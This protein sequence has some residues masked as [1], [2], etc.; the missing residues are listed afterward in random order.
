MLKGL[1]LFFSKLYYG[2][3]KLIPEEQRKNFYEEITNINH[4]RIKPL[5]LALFFVDLILVFLDLTF[6]TNIPRD[7]SAAQG[8]LTLHLLGLFVFLL[9]A[10]FFFF[11]YF[12]LRFWAKRFSLVLF[13][14]LCL[15]WCSLVSL[16]TYKLYGQILAIV[17]GMLSAACFFMLNRFSRGLFFSLTYLLFN[18]MLR[19]VEQNPGYIAGFWIDTTIVLVLCFFISNFCFNTFVDQYI[20]RKIIINNIKEIGR[21]NA[22]LEQK[23][24]ERTEALTQAYAQIEL[25]KLRVSFFTNL[26]H[27]F[28]TPINVILSAQQLLMLKLKMIVSEED[29]KSLKNNI[30]SIEKYSYRL[31]R[32]VSNTIDITRIDT[33][34]YDLCLKNVNIVHIVEEIV[35]S[36]SSFIEA[37]MLSIVF[38][39][40]TEERIMAVDVDKIERAILN[41]LSNAIK[42]TPKNGHIW[43]NLYEEST[44]FY[45]SVRDSGIGIPAHMKD[46]IFN[47]FVQVDKTLTRE[48]EGSG[49]GLSIV[50]SII[51]L[52]QG[53]ITVNSDLYSGSEFIICLPIHMLNDMGQY[54][55][56][57]QDSLDLL[58]IELSDIE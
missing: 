37:R 13:A 27:E 18:L 3:I 7:S 46:A 5:S 17:V 47:R 6:L 42:F 26:S 48:Q 58:K 57:G 30:Y 11:A 28:R 12:R 14:E 35:L 52:H 29:F 22:D 56:E 21:L 36:V 32:M 41:L 53:T 50:K 25:E 55:F 39:T 24:Q 2:D 33:G 19:S 23:V 51:E 31:M 1:G 38:D 40:Q 44:F 34:H 20:N 4:S 15:L 49:L 43:V 16:Q 8:I 45:I 10:V 54:C 9:A